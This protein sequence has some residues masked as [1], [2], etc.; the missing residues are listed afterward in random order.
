MKGRFHVIPHDVNEALGG[1]GGFG[2]FGGG[3][4]GPTLDPLVAVNDPG[5]PLR[6]SCW[7]SRPAPALSWIHASE[8]PR[9]LSTECVAPLANASHRLM[10]RT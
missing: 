3:G 9:N 1:D 4:G 7:R 2:G 10:R 8:S 6:S 5:K